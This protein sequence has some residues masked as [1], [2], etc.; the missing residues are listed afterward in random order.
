MAKKKWR[1][2]FVV[3]VGGWK[4]SSGNEGYNEDVDQVDVDDAV[5]AVTEVSV[6]VDV[7]DCSNDDKI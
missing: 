1:R 5:N 2:D 4:R 7:E 6:D 3:E